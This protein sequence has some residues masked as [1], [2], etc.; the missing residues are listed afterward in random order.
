MYL[1]KSARDGF[2]LI[3]FTPKALNCTETTHGCNLR[4]NKKRKGEVFIAIYYEIS[5]KALKGEM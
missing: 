4:I 2:F 5:K 3:L 1:K